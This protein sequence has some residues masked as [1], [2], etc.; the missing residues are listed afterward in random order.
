M[1]FFMEGG[2]E[3]QGA[4]RQVLQRF[5]NL[6]AAGNQDFF[7]LAVEIGKDFRRAFFTAAGRVGGPHCYCQFEFAGSNN[8]QQ[9]FAQSLSRSFPVELSLADKFPGHVAPGCASRVPCSLPA[10]TS[11]RARAWRGREGGE[12]DSDTTAA[13]SRQRSGSEYTL[14]V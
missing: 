6:S 4:K 5:Q 8:F 12:S 10:L 1:N 9:K 7:V 11:W 14:P 2:F 3:P 13:K